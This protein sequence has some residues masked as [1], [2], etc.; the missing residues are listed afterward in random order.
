MLYSLVVFVS[1]ASTTEIYHETKSTSAN[2][3]AHDVGKSL[4]ACEIN[5]ITEFMKITGNYYVKTIDI[6]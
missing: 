5:F 6:D 3:N 2:C 4:S 1:P